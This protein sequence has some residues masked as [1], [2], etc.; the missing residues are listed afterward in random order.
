MNTN[1][2]SSSLAA[3]AFGAFASLAQAAPVLS[4]GY[5]SSV[6]ATLPGPNSNFYGD[7]ALDAN[8]NR[9]V[10]GGLSQSVYKVTAAGAVSS[11]VNPA[12]GSTVISVAVVGND[13][14]VG[15]ESMNLTRVNLTNGV[16][17]TLASS[18]GTALAMA[19]GAGKFY[20]GT[21]TGL[22]AYDIASNSYAS[23][24]AGNGIFNSLAFAND[25]RLL[26]SD[27]QNSR[28]LSY[29]TAN[30]TASVFRSGIN[31]V[32]GVA[33]HAG[34]GKVYAVSE[35][36]NQMLEISAD[37]SSSSLFASNLLA[38]GGY[39]PSALEFSNDF[40]QLMYLQRGTGNQFQLA[41]INGFSAVS[42]T[43]Q[44]PEPQSLALTFAALA[45]LALVRR[46]S[47]RN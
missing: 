26:I 11:Y 42:N 39:Y 9:Y 30:N 37:G 14:Y 23:T 12:A 33:V 18:N 8:G 41:A 17:T 6:L 22:Y 40:S 45:G 29:N 47:K 1:K 19:Y 35:G 44:V 28:L 5:T 15:S 16:Q 20:I 24:G 31:S 3:L 27:S 7:I 2:L 38:D 32:G 36:L 21:N 46:R 25:G 13:L 43:T 4:A 34:T 10:T